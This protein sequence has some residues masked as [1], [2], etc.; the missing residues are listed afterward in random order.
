MRTVSGGRRHTRSLRNE[1][2]ENP[3]AVSVMRPGSRTELPDHKSADSHDN[4]EKARVRIL[5]KEIPGRCSRAIHVR[6]EAE[7]MPVSENSYKSCGNCLLSIADHDMF[8]GLQPR[9]Q[10]QYWQPIPCPSC[11][12]ILSEIREHSGK[13]IRHCFACHFEFTVSEENGKKS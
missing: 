2:S 10:C 11:G 1:Q 7:V 13:Q 8:C 6:T 9:E 12:G 3:Y 5:Q 4:R